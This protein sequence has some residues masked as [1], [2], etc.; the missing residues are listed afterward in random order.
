MRTRKSY[1]TFSL[2][3]AFT[4]ALLIMLIPTTDLF[5]SLSEQLIPT[6]WVRLPLSACI[7]FSSLLVFAWL[8][9]KTSTSAEELS[10]MGRTMKRDD[11]ISAVQKLRAAKDDVVKVVMLLGL[12][13][14]F[15]ET[16]RGLQ[17]QIDGMRIAIDVIDNKIIELD[18]PQ[19]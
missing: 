2:A 16:V 8:A 17:T 14:A 6:D 19:K 10:I 1:L 15:Q 7:S 18:F 5:K 13:S 12:D 3:L 9:P 11:L 4:A